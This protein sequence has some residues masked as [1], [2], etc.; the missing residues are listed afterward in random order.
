MC[1]GEG[2]KSDARRSLAVCLLSVEAG[3]VT[4][5]FLLHTIHYIIYRSQH[6][7]TLTDRAAC[8]DCVCRAHTSPCLQA[9]ASRVPR[10]AHVTSLY[11]RLPHESVSIDT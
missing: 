2:F 6:R 4:M 11:M 8:S 5:P 10:S 3:S 7:T 1:G 9:P